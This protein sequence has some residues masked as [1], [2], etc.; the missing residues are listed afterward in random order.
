MICD[1][2]KHQGVI[3]WDKL[4]PK[5]D[6]VVIKASGKY[7]NGADPYYASN[8]A[9]AVSHGV[10]FHVF[11]FLYCL[12]EAQAKRDAALFYNTVK[13]QGHM[14]LFW[15]L[16]CEKG[17]GI[18]RTKAKTIAE[19]FEEELRRLA[20]KSIRVALY[21]G[22]DKYKEYAMNYSRYAYIWIPRYGRNDGTVESSIFPDHPCDLWQFT[23]RGKAP[24]INT[25]VD[26]D[27]LT[28][29]KPMSFF[30]GENEQTGGKDMAV[31]IGS[32]RIDENGKA[33]GGAAGDQTGKEVSTQSWYKHSKG[34]RVFRAK[35]PIVAEKIAQDMQ[36]ACDSSY[37]GYDQG[38][39]LTLYN[40]S[41]P[42]GFNCKKVKEKCE[43][44]CSALV[45]VCC[46]YAG[47]T[48]PNFRT[49]TEPAALLDSGAFVEMKGSKYTDQ[50]TYLKRGD[51]LCTKTQGHTVVVLSNGSKA[52]NDDPTDTSL[53]RGDEGQDVMAMQKALLVWDANCLPEYGAD[54]DFGGETEAAVKA[55]QKAAGL[56][57]T[58]VYDAETKK[59]LTS[60]GKQKNVLVTGGSVN[61]RT[62]PGYDTK[63]LGVAHKG[64]LLPYQGED[65][66]AEG[67]VWHLV[68]FKNQNAWI[69]GKYSRIEA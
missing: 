22:H 27:I 3:N 64:D 26:L 19:T 18:P 17:W 57:V 50:S 6:F 52:D 13:S 10:P 9:G 4:A 33:R 29:T 5:L 43:T 55:Y 47:I 65:K 63:V 31:K 54:G 68:A 20:G 62:A 69:S 16:D 1:V 30:T 45:R 41:K 46:A 12:T 23:S 7:A 15:V 51:I 49:P 53:R 35:D 56:P 21:I 58:G 38:Q 34:W 8:V 25:N 40:V 37:I 24:G 32:A 36:W 14:P 11:H 44:D 61:V 28:G 39:R 67:V 59:S 48:L 66:T 60:I 42:L 2:S